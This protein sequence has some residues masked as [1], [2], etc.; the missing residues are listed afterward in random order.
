MLNTLKLNASEFKQQREKI[1]EKWK[2]ALF[3]I[4]ESSRPSLFSVANRLS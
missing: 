2:L 3:F 4:M 1:M